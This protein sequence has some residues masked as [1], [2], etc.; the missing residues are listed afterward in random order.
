MAETAQLSKPLSYECR[1]AFYSKSNQSDDD[2]HF[3]KEIQ[4]FADGTTKPTTRI[5]KNKKFP[6]YV[7]KKGAQ[8]HSS[9]KEAEKIDNLIKYESTATKLTTNA[10]R[11]LGMSWFNGS[12]RDLHKNPYIYGTDMLSTTRVKMSYMQKWPD[13]ITPYTVACFDTETDVLYGSDQILMATVSFKER[14]FTAVQKSFVTGYVD[15]EN[16]LQQLASLYIGDDIKARNIKIEFIIVD[17]ELDVVKRCMEKSHEWQPDFLAV[18]NLSFDMNKIIEACDRAKVAPETI[19]NDPSV[20]DEY[21]TFKFKMGAAKKVTASGKVMNYKPS[22]RWHSVNSPAS[23]YWI[24]AMCAYRQIRTGRPEEPSYA[25]DAI[26][27]KN[28]KRNKL[29]FEQASEYTDLEWHKFM[30]KNHPLEYIIYNVF[31]CV[32]MEILDE[33]TLDLSLTL[34]MFARATDFGNFNSQPKRLCDDL[35]G[36]YM[37]RGWVFG[38]TSSEMAEEED[39]ETAK[40]SDW[41][42]ALPA[43]LNYNTG[44]KVIKDNP[45][46]NTNIRVHCAD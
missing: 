35:Y 39:E 12:L 21:K 19:L 7:T 27:E 30:Q 1:F 14:V 24:D 16:R 46:Y 44:L 23:F 38:T 28:I 11:A 5:I 17:T 31:D 8:N 43:E 36:F 15:V 10:A 22:Q 18:W 2:I 3:V 40:L 4:H 32:G 33:K 25:L 34:P 42:I 6:F 26:L 29:K 13:K 45:D 41:I 9:K 20:P 37:E